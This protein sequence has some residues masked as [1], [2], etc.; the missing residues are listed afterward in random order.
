MH[1]QSAFTTAMSHF[2][3]GL[4]GKNDLEAAMIDMVVES[5]F[6]DSIEVK[7]IFYE[8]SEEKRVRESQ[9]D[10]TRIVTLY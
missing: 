7:G 8:P 6:D 5:C 2:V 10:N 9:Q 4:S 3:E 1:Q